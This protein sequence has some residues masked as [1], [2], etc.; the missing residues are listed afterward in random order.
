MGISKIKEIFTP[1]FKAISA[2]IEKVQTLTKQDSM[3]DQQIMDLGERNNLL[4]N[5]LARSN[6]SKGLVYLKDA[7]WLSYKEHQFLSNS[8]EQS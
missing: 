5:E 8:L 7:G 3:L 1:R 2:L 4:K 6:I